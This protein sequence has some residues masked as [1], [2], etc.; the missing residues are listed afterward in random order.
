MPSY[1]YSCK[2]C[3]NS[4]DEIHAIDD[5]NKPLEFPCSQCG[6]FTLYIKIGT[7]PMSYQGGGMNITDNFND[8]LKEIKKNLPAEA[9]SKIS[10]N[11]KR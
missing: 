6:N 10:D 9:R 3:G 4:F 8:R 2:T 1:N 11:M 7:V 5:R